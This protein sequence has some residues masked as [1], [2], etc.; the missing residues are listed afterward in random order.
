MIEAFASLG[1][2]VPLLMEGA[3]TTLLL[4]VL[5]LP[6]GLLIALPF[7]FAR[8][9]SQ[10][11]LRGVGHGFVLL[12][13]GAPLL[14][15]LFLVYYGLPQVPGIRQSA[16]WFLLRDPFPVAL[17]ALSLNS[18]GFQ[19]HIIAGALR[20]VPANEIEAARAAGFSRMQLL[21][22]IIVPH[23]IRL[24]IRS[25]GNEAVFV[26]KG[27]AVVSFITVRDLMSAANQVYFRT[28]E[29]VPPL[30][31]AA[32]VYLVIVLAVSRIVRRVELR[33]TPQLRMT[34]LRRE[35]PQAAR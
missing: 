31:V 13:R 6:I 10:P 35:M 30:V 8:N 34:R 20:N 25:F 12:F 24:G 33:L 22:F 14:V 21:R 1:P 28:F 15:I 11:V 19:T 26:L 3:T 27:T 9:A 2:Y 23:A 17:V 32:L 16:I 18:A 4:F 29:P 5:T 7:A